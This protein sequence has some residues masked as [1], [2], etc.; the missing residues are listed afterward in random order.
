MENLSNCYE[1][2]T[3]TPPKKMGFNRKQKEL[4]GETPTA[5][6]PVTD[7]V[8]EEAP[9]E[10]EPTPE[11]IEPRPVE[12]L[13][14]KPISRE[15]LARR[16]KEDD[17]FLPKEGGRTVFGI[18][19]SSFK[20][21]GDFIRRKGFS[22]R[23]FRTKSF[24]NFMEKQEGHMSYYNN[25]VDR[26]VRKVNGAFKKASKGLDKEQVTQL[27]QAFDAAVRGDMNQPL[28]PRS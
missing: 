25:L 28:P 13:E 21:F 14:Q 5:T 17:V 22:S 23:S 1:T 2:P 3:A 12:P 4:D 8:S 16:Q 9:A 19:V 18:P 6:P 20:D 7:E 26:T 15:E 10:P 24:R 27:N 11:P